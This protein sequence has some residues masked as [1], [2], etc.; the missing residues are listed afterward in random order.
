MGSI[1]KKRVLVSALVS[2]ILVIGLMPVAAFATSERVD[3]VDL[4]SYQAVL[5]KLN[6]EYGTEVRFITQDDID[7]LPEGC[8]LQL[9]TLSNLLPLE[10]FE[11]QA[12]GICRL[13]AEENREYEEMLAELKSLEIVFEEVDVSIAN[14]GATRGTSYCFFTYGEWG[15]AYGAKKYDTLQD[16]YVWARFD[17]ASYKW[18]FDNAYYLQYN[19]FSPASYT[20][21]AVGE[22]RM[23]IDWSGIFYPPL[24]VAYLTHRA[25]WYHTSGL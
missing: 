12:R 3:V 16:C 22:Y 17:G 14:G 11:N 10:E 25:G 21:S 2:V 24:G 18:N 4:S 6:E 5:D 7:A 19:Y 9:P 13:S 15:E 23:W 20:R 1:K 8:S